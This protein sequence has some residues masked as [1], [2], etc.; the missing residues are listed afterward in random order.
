MANMW[1][2]AGPVRAILG[3]WQVNGIATFRSGVPLSLAMASNTL[4]NF[5]GAQRPDQ[6][7][8]SGALSGKIST[9]VSRYFDPLS[10]DPAYFDTYSTVTTGVRGSFLPGPC[11]ANAL[12]AGLAT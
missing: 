4:F 12:A 8:R 6:T 7:D 9:R 2:N 11:Y 5:G 1:R 10:F 3:N